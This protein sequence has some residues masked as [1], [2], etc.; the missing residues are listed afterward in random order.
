MFEK[1]ELDWLGGS[2][3]P[4]APDA[5]E[6]LQDK[7]FH[8]PSSASTF[9]SFNTETFPFSNLN[10]RKAFSEA[11]G[12][13]EIVSQVCTDQIP[14]QTMLPP[15]FTTQL[16]RLSDSIA[17]KEHFQKALEQLK[18]SAAELENLTLYYKPGQIEKRVAQT[19]QKQWKE[20]LGVT[21]H[22]V[23]LDFKSHAHRLQNRDYQMALS[24][25]IAQ[26]D[27]AVSILERFKDKSHLKNYPGWQNSEYTLLLEK[28][29]FSKKRDQVLLQAEAI[30]A[31]KLPLT[32]I[33]HWSS[34]AISN[35]RICSIGTTPSG[36]ILFE[37]FEISALAKYK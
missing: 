29:P 1:G 9:C 8:I 25:W 26:F 30:L 19:I 32:P 21:V 15:S 7:I 23:Q 14:A 11:I 10:L 13:R 16:V 2:L 3:S 6:K 17:A 12:R 37:K 20:V 34:P 22:L 33:Y 24:S 5:L 31:D 35:A 27:D 28:A 4:I 18:I 36:G